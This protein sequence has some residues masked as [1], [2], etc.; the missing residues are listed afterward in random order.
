MGEQPVLDVQRADFAVQRF[1]EPAV[2]F[3]FHEVGQHAVVIPTGA[4][5]LAPPVEVGTVASDVDH[6]VD[7]R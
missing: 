6:E 3:G 4:T 2:R 7:R 1:S 5:P